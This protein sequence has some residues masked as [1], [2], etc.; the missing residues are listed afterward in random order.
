MRCAQC[1]S[2]L[3]NSCDHG[4]K[5]ATAPQKFGYVGQNALNLETIYPNLNLTLSRSAGLLPIKWHGALCG[6]VNSI[7]VY[8]PRIS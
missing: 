3:Y 8:L 5:G 6:C 2:Q 1:Y 7:I 4:A